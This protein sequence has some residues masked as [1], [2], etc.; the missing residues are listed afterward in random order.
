MEDLSL[1][2]EDLWVMGMHPGEPQCNRKVLGDCDY[3]G[4]SFLMEGSNSK[5]KGCGTVKPLT[6]NSTSNA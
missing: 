2:P 5:K 4:A 3:E 1:G 6:M